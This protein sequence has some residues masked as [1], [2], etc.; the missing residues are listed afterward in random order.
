MAEV[1]INVNT[2]KTLTNCAEDKLD[3]LE[4]AIEEA[5]ER[6]V[7]EDNY[8]YERLTTERNALQR[9]VETARELVESEM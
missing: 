8:M 9:K 5:E 7:P 6:G 2:L 4:S 3:K 1:S